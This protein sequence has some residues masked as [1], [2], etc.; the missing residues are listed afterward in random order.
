MR[1]PYFAL[2]DHVDIGGLCGSNDM[3]NVFYVAFAWGQSASLIA[4][5]SERWQ[6]EQFSYAREIPYSPHSWA[7]ALLTFSC[8][9]AIGFTLHDTGDPHALTAWGWFIVIGALGCA[10]WCAYYSWCFYQS[11]QDFPDQVSYSGTYLW[12]CF[13]LWY[14]LKVGQQEFKT[15]PPRLS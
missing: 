3:Y 1:L 5:G 8:I 9:L 13:A 15:T 2:R 7:I 6:G 4:S 14:M 12:A 10:M 11:G